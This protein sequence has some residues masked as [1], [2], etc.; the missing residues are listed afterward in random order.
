MTVKEAQKD[1]RAITWP[2]KDVMYN[3][4]FTNSE[5]REDETQFDIHGMRTLQE[6]IEV[7]SSLFEDFCKENGFRSDSVCGIYLA[8]HIEE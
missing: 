1:L 7:L 4:G 5:G 2:Q 8:G 6:T 3:I